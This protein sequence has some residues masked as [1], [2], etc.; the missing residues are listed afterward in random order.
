MHE[1]IGYTI[2]SP[3]LQNALPLTLAPCNGGSALIVQS[4]LGG[5]E[6]GFG[7]IAYDAGDFDAR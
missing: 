1:Q 6:R 3:S 4:A 2:W 5:S 7:L